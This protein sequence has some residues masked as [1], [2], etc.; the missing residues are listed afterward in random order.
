MINEVRKSPDY[1]NSAVNLINPPEIQTKLQELHSIQEK[2]KIWKDALEKMEQYQ[3]LKTCEQEIADKI[4][5]IRGMIDFL[6]SYQN[7]DIGYA[8]KQRKLSI[9]YDA[10]SF[11]SHYPEL[12]PAVLVKSVNIKAIEGLLKGQLLDK[13]RLEAEGVLKISESFAYVIK[14]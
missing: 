2:A 14:V 8:V 10:S 5:E 4:I 1:S 12:A 7:P 6:G 3:A 13:A 9:S 11:E